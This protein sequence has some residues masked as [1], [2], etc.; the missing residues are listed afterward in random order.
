MLLRNWVYALLLVFL[1]GAMTRQP[2]PVA[3]SIAAAIVLTVT[4][5]WRKHALDHIH[6]FRQWIYRR[7]FPGENLD[8]RVTVE[9]RKL[10]PISWIKIVDPW[11]KAAG[12]EDETVLSASHIEEMGELVN[13]YSLRWRQRIE[14]LYHLTLRRRGVY[15]IGPVELT[16]GD[17]FGMYETSQTIDR[18]D[19]VVIFPELLAFTSL[20]LPIQDPFGERSSPRRLFEDPT[21]S[22]AIRPYQPGDSF[23]QIHWNAT[24]RTGEMQVRVYQ[25]VSARVLMLCLNA[26]TQPLYWLGVD[27]DRLE[28]LIKITATLAYQ[29][30]Q[31]GYAV[32]LLSNGC[33]AHSDQAFHLPPGRS[34]DHLAQLLTALASV[35]PF[36]TAPFE[37]YLSHTMP[38]IP[39]GASLVV[40]SALVSPD[41]CASLMQVNR[42]RGNTTLISLSSDPVPSIPGIRTIRMDY[43]GS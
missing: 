16:S 2:W 29:G 41:L 17:L 33:L 5:Q 3:F 26:S 42:Y 19:R 9:N 14:R 13:I 38:K 36:T 34:T 30:I 6:Y 23:R 32:G 22:M 18:V 12:P 10:L 15:L 20:P 24:A 1:I 8:V 35:T 37:T 7:G 25:P 31:D 27:L 40:I 28:H 21:Q 4:V 39:Y 43:P 11:P